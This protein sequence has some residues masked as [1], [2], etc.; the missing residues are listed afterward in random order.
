[1][2]ISIIDSVNDRTFPGALQLANDA[3]VE[4]RPNIIT[5][6]R[7]PLNISIDLPGMKKEN[8]LEVKNPTYGNV[9]AAIDELISIWNDK[10]STTHTLPARTQ[11]SESM[12]Y[13]KKSNI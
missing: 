2:D 8:T 13:S 3:F 7:K 6:K 5:S 4:N 10:Y 12:V 9:S 11:Y 1:M